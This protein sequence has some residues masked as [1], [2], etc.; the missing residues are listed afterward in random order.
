MKTLKPLNELLAAMSDPFDVD[1]DLERIVKEIACLDCEHT[2][3]PDYLMRL[4]VLI[5]K[6]GDTPDKDGFDL[7]TSKAIEYAYSLTKHHLHEQQEYIESLFEPD[8]VKASPVEMEQPERPANA[9]GCVWITQ[10]EEGGR[11]VDIP[12]PYEESE[13]GLS[14]GLVDDEGQAKMV[15]VLRPGKEQPIAEVYTYVSEQLSEQHKD[16]SVRLC[17]ESHHG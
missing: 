14:V 7:I 1:G 6:A 3:R 13:R 17:S 12:I 16:L 2:S 5:Q 8:H 4:L 15:I 10:D 11:D 9:V